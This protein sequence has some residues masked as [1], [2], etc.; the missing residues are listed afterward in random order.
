MSSF[1]GSAFTASLYLRR[2]PCTQPHEIWNYDQSTSEVHARAVQNLKCTVIVSDC[3][4]QTYT[5]SSV[6]PSQ[7]HG[8]LISG[9]GQVAW[10][11]WGSWHKHA[12]GL[13]FQCHGGCGSED[14]KVGALG[15]CTADMPCYVCFSS[16]AWR[17]HLQAT[18]QVWRGRCDCMYYQ[19]QPE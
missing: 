4:V 8:G 2:A 11:L 3:S 12:P 9:L 10:I 1:S 13:N 15:E 17:C 5:G 19:S 14:E 7:L 16:R 6:V 18:A